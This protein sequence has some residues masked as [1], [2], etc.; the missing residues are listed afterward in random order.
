[1]S[2]SLGI[3]KGFISSSFEESFKCFTRWSEQYG[4]DLVEWIYKYGKYYV[5]V[6]P[7]KVK[8]RVKE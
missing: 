4:E 3:S 2:E 8:E 1:M 7:F 6:Y 5:T